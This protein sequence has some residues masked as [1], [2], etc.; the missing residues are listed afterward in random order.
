MTDTIEPVKLDEDDKQQFA[1]RLVD[2]AR[3][4]GVDLAAQTPTAV[5]QDQHAL[6]SAAEAASS[7][8]IHDGG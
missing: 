3:S 4:E 2:Q 6:R 1:Q 5:S 8:C 7:A